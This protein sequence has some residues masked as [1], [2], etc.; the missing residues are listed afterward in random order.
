[1]AAM[2]GAELAAIRKSAGLS[3]TALAK[4]AGI[5]RHAVSYWECKARVDRYAWAVERM[6]GVL[7]LPP[8]PPITIASPSRRDGLETQLQAREAAFMAMVARN[9]ARSA[10]H[11]AQLRV[12]CGARTRKGTPCRMKS[13]PGKRRCKFHGGLSTGARTP[14]GIERIRNAQRQRWAR[15]QAAQTCRNEVDKT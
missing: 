1:M 6:A 9:I 14:E 12:P 4:C 13:V 15:W 5:G 2:T 7:D 8:A 3:Q 11:K 10:R